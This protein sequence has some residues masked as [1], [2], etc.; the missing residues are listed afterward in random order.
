LSDCVSCIVNESCRA[1]C[2][3]SFKDNCQ[4][5]ADTYDCFQSC[6]SLFLMQTCCTGK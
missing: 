4:C 6:L 1:E 3:N 5:K 2:G